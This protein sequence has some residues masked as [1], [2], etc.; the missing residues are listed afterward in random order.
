MSVL[1]IDAGT[2]GVTA[3]VVS[4]AGRIVATALPGV[5]AALP[6]ARV[7]GARAGG[8]LAGHPRGHPGGAGQGRRLRADR[9]RHHQPARDR[10]ALGPR[11][12]RVAASGDR[13]A[14]PAD[15]RDLR[16][17]ARRGP[18]GAGRRADRAPARPLLLRHQ[19][20]VAGRA[21][22]A[23][24]G[25]RPVGPVRRRDRRLLPDRPDDPGHLAR[26]RRL[27]RLPDPALRPRL[28][29]LVRRALQPLRRAPRR[30]ARPGPQLGRGRARRTRGPS[31]ASSCPSRASPATSSRPSSARRAST[32]RRLQVHLRH[33]VLHPDQHRDHPRALRRRPALHGGLALARRAS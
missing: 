32:S 31:S 19:A 8:D 14:G 2:T 28:R 5:R 22:A 18:R 1:A 20:D 33:R 29:R 9:H 10:R 12:P 15:G 4:P 23:H 13:V 21:R 25:P 26:H 3:V 16:A 24:V 6:Q 27:Q 17:A 30:A 11:D 7:G